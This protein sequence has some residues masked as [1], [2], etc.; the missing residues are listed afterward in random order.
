MSLVATVLA[1]VL[2]HPS[3]RLLVVV[4]LAQAAP[5]ALDVVGLAVLAPNLR[6]AHIGRVSLA[7]A[8]LALLETEALLRRMTWLATL[9][10]NQ[11]AALVGEMAVQTAPHTLPAS[12][13]SVADTTTLLAHQRAALVRLVAECTT[14]VTLPTLAR[15]SP[16]ALVTLH[17]SRLGT[18]P[19]Q[20]TLLMTVATR[21][22]G[23]LT[24][25]VTLLVTV[26]AP[27]RDGG[28]GSHSLWSSPYTSA[29]LSARNN[30]RIALGS[31]DNNV[32]VC[33]SL[34]YHRRYVIG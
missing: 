21:R 24:N 1:L 31:A 11:R 2:G 10:A 28:G 18:V 19:I 27:G 5:K 15:V 26:V 14:L 33:V 6:L 8:T 25:L 13:R 20:M 29:N 34:E 12:L 7:K 16:L 32:A 23:T 4:L 17:R 22:L 30:N 3:A 9:V